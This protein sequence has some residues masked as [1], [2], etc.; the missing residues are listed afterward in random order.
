MGIFDMSCYTISMIKEEAKRWMII[1]DSDYESSLYLFKGS[2]YPQAIYML[3]QSIE[4]LLKATLIEIANKPPKKIHRLE[5]IAQ[6]SGLNFSE[7]QY[8][9][10]TDLSKHYSRVRYPDISRESYNTKIK[11][12]P[13]MKEGKQIYLWIQQQLNNR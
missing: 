10:L 11:V 6:E 4:K 8:N 12:E 13:I 5:N 1:A 7:E 9:L 3:C 2:R